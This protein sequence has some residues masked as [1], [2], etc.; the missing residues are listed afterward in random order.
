MTGMSDLI[1][2]NTVDKS[3]LD[4]LDQ[5]D[6]DPDLAAQMLTDIGFSKGADGVWVDDTGKRMAFYADLSSADYS[7]W[8]AAARK[9]HAGTQRFRF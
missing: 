7:D 1:A 9:R 4:G 5:Y 3:V 6:Y 2:E 8:A